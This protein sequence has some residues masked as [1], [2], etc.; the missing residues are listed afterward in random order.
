MHPSRMMVA[1][2]LLAALPCS[3][4]AA[5]AP[6]LATGSEKSAC[7]MGALAK[8]K[9]T[10][11]ITFWFDWGQV[12]GDE[13]RA[14]VDRFNGSQTKVKIDATFHGNQ[15]NPYAIADDYVRAVKAGAGPDL[16]SANGRTTQLM[17]DSATT[18]PMAACVASDH[19]DL[20]DLLPAVRATGESG[21]T[22]VAMPWGAGGEVLV[23]NRIAFTK[24]GL[25]PDKP[26]SNLAELRSASKAIMQTGAAK[27]GLSVLALSNPLKWL[28]DAN[29]EA[30]FT[31]NAAGRAEHSVL[32]SARGRN[33]VADY[34]DM[35]KTGELIAFPLGPNPDYL[36]AVASGDAAMAFAP[37]GVLGDV[38]KYLRDNNVPGLEPAVGPM[39]AATERR[40]FSLEGAGAPLWIVKGSN[41][42]KREAAYRFAKWLVEPD[43]LV[44]WAST[45][46]AIPIRTSAASLPAMTDFWKAHPLFRVAYDQL[47]HV[48]PTSAA[49]VRTGSTQV[50]TILD[51]LIAAILT[52]SADPATSVPAAMVKVDAAMAEYNA[53]VATNAATASGQG[54][55]KAKK[56]TANSSGCR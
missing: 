26:P 40:D 36:I 41:A 35:A 5:R 56:T 3:V 14:L 31:A 39:P 24:A 22:L 12:R 20:S 49:T 38:Q 27:H 53:S 28:F 7:P 19:V 48:G 10:T 9:G 4:A 23:Y 32:S 6:G 54:V 15:Y 50:E 8:A 46:G 52:R 33:I 21:G 29:G 30:W 34:A 2:L 25:D 16:I 37:A 44:E 47:P 17:I 45:T 43:Q 11:K 51:E 55:C 42:A 18:I 1:S 13:V